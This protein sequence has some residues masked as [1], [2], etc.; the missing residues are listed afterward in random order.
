[1]PDINRAAILTPAN[2][3]SCRRIDAPHGLEGEGLDHEQVRGPDGLS[4]V[5]EEGAPA[6]AGRS[7]W[8]ATPV[9]ADGA[10][11]DGDAELA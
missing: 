7:G 9:A 6:L 10:G 2:L 4:V 1:M 3:R 11:A 8:P 5:G